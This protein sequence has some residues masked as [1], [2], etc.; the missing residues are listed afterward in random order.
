MRLFCAGLT[1]ALELA[2][3]LFAAP[4]LAGTPLDLSAPETLADNTPAPAPAPADQTAPQISGLQ[5][6]FE[7]WFARSDA[8]KASQPQFAT[9]LITTNPMLEQRFRFDVPIEHIGNGSDTTNLDGGKGLDLIV[10]DTQEIQIGTPPYTIHSTPTGKGEYS[11]WADW[12]VFRFKQR[13]LSSPA[14][15]GNYVLSAWLQIQVPT[16]IEALTNHAVTLLPTV[17]GGKGFGPFTIL[18]NAGAAIPT[19]YEGKLGIQVTQNVALEYALFPHFTPMI[20]FNNTYYSNG[21]RDG[22]DQLFITPVLNI[23]RIP[24]TKGLNLTLVGGYQ[25]AVTPKFQ[26]KPLLPAYDHAWIMSTRFNF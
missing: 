12:P 1:S 5:A 7:D 21:Q 13:L 15:Q 4:A 3:L 14:D 11:G 2:G 18:L 16:G 22:R 24:I 19:A 25:T 20:E 6:Y 17:G 8:A 23:G 26:A 10:S 9:P